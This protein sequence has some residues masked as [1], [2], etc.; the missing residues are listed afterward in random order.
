MTDKRPTRRNGGTTNPENHLRR[1]GVSG[2]GRVGTYAAAKNAQRSR[3]HRC[4]MITVHDDRDRDPEKAVYGKI[5]AVPVSR[6]GTHKTKKAAIGRLLEFAE[7][8]GGEVS[9]DVG[10]YPT[11]TVKDVIEPELSVDEIRE[12]TRIS[13]G[14]PKQDET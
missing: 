5:G 9:V 8:V 10:G 13:S 12:L 4:W 6:L 3:P 2:Y 1:Y 7:E 14:R 11:V